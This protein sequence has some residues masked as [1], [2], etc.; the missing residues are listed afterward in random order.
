VNL[1]TLLG[2]GDA[3]PFLEIK[4]RTWSSRDAA[5]RAALIGELLALIGLDEG[6]LVKQEYV[7][8]E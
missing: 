4:S 2:G 3:G 1:D 5:E 6:A 7:E 8:M